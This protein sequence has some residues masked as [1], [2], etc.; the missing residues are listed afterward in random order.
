MV[1]DS[2]D[3]YGITR[4]PAPRCSLE[5]RHFEKYLHH[6]VLK[7]TQTSPKLFSKIETKPF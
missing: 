1:H 3:A 7:P 5:T 4:C 2:T 6:Q